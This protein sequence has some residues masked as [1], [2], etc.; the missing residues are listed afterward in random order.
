MYRIFQY[1]NDS[2]FISKNSMPTFKVNK[3]KLILYNLTFIIIIYFNDKQQK[4]D[5]Y[6]KLLKHMQRIS[7]NCIHSGV[8]KESM[9]FYYLCYYYILFH[10]Y[11]TLFHNYRYYL[12]IF[13]YNVL[14]KQMFISIIF[15]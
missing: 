6:D 11:H 7:F 8:T 3:D 12:T 1:K 4:Y 2:L 13:N 10:N 14:L 15:I 5:K 9:K